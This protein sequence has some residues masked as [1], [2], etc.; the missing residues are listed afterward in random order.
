MHLHILIT[1]GLSLAPIL[2]S[3]QKNV[4]GQPLQPCSVDPMTGFYRNGSCETGDMDHG[5]HVICSR[6]TEAFLVFSK[7]RGNDLSTPRPEY[8]FPGLKAGDKWCL[9][10]LRWEEALLAGVAPPVVLAST[11][12]R[13]LEFVS[14]DSLRS[15][16]V[17]ANDAAAVSPSDN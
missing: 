11:H 15:H 4:L 6:V 9:C 16:A 8:N 7:K 12:E 13:A 3:A 17:P 5:T 14:L 10:A 1:I 2:M